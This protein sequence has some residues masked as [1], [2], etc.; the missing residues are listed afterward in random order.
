MHVGE[1][2]VPASTRSSDT[3]QAGYDYP[4]D[5]TLEHNGQ[6]SLSHIAIE[7]FCLGITLGLSLALGVLA[8]YHNYIVWRL[9]G[10]LG[11]LAIFHLL[12]FWTTARFNTPVVQASSFLLFTNGKAYNI[13]YLLA[14]LEILL[15]TLAFPQYG[16]W[17]SGWDPRLAGFLLVLLGQVVRSLAMAH[18]GRSFN[19]TPQRVRKESHTL[20]TTGVYAYLRHP[21]Y[22]GFFWWAIGTQLF[23]GNKFCVLGYIIVLWGFFNRRI[24]AE[25]KQLVSFF[26]EDYEKFRK[27][28]STGIPFIR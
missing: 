4:Y 26:G 18:A 13:A 2:E 12:E 9:F 10:F 6:R 20:V 3:R 22:F 19:H 14:L 15:S 17:L 21:S 8:A 5:R 7:A 11:C 16:R 24:I 25:E 27:N 23:V 28:T 1:A